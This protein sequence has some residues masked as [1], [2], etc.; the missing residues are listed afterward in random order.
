MVLSYK[1]CEEDN[2]EGVIGHTGEGVC[3]ERGGGKDKE[4]FQRESEW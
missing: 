4:A 2:E 1:E 3:Y